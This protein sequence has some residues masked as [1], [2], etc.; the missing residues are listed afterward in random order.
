MTPAAIAICVLCQL[1]LVGG[2]IL[3]KHGMN[4]THRQPRP[5][6]TILANAG[7]ALALL[8]LWYFLWLGLLRDWDLSRLYAFESLGPP[9]LVLGA[10]LFLKER[11]TVRAWIGIILIGSGIGLVAIG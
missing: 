2:Q 10:W 7:G 3:L 6:L 11:V 1:C 5:I 9:M 4:A 8:G